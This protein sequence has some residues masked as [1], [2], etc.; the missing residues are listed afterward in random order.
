LGLWEQS[1]IS[2]HRDAGLPPAPDALRCV[3]ARLMSS[4]RHAGSNEDTPLIVEVTR[5]FVDRF[6][7]SARQDLDADVLLGGADEDCLVDMLADL[8]WEHR[9]KVR[10]SQQST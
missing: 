6:A 7:W 5:L 10:P 1:A 9:G 2:I 3:L 8:A 4:S